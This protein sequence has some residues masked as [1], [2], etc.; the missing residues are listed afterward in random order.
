MKPL[1]TKYR[2]FGQVSIYKRKDHIYIGMVDF[3][4]HKG[5]GLF[6]QLLA[7]LEQFNKPIRLKICT[8][9]MD[10]ETLKK[11]YERCGFVE[12]GKYFEKK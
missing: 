3:R 4:Q 6:K 9:E 7:E 5:K 2:N 8:F 1:L 10:F 11:I 12:K